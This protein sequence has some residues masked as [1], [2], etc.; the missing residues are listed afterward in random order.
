MPK[1]TFEGV[2][3]AFPPAPPLLRGLTW[4]VAAG[5]VVALMG[6]SGCGKTSLLRLLAGLQT[7]GA[8][9]VRIGAEAPSEAVRHGKIGMVFQQP[10]LYPHLNVAENLAMGWQLQ[11][12][13]GRKSWGTMR[14]RAEV[15][16]RLDQAAELLELGPLLSRKPDYLSGGERQRVALGRLL[17]RRPAVFLL[18]E[19]L[20]FLDT[21]RARAVAQRL[22]PLLRSWGTTAV[23]VTHEHAE[24]EIV[25]D[26]LVRLEQGQVQERAALSQT[27]TAR[28]VGD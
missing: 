24:A 6:P 14:P 27:R 5:E 23:W 1:L 26:R 12:N 13:L 22:A 18:D 4:T 3:L 21:D 9:Q 28:S 25:A 10:V 7:P 17:V 19:P 20:A 11:Y 8:G 15:R 2:H 16:Q